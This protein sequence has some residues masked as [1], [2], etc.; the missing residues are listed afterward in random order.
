ML[1]AQAALTYG[2]TMKP[3]EFAA[4]L[5]GPTMIALHLQDADTQALTSAVNK[6]TGGLPVVTVISS[7]TQVHA[8]DVASSPFWS[9]M[10]AVEKATGQTCRTRAARDGGMPW[11]AAK[12]PSGR[13]MPP[14]GL[15][16]V[17]LVDA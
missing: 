12:T 9:A 6:Q 16:T 13:F 8:V 11:Q 4:Q 5:G 17:A 1:A 15:F 10:L 7:D 2:K 3:D 14:A